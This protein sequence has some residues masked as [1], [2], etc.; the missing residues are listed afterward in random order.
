[1]PL[2][3]QAI[4]DEKFSGSPVAEIFTRVPPLVGPIKGE[5]RVTLKQ[6]TIV[7]VTPLEEAIVDE[8]LIPRP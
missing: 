5:I 2:A 6:E 4:G 7:T 8:G 1:M 3:R